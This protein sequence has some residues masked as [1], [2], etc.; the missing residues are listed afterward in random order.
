[1]KIV[2]LEF[3]GPF[4]WLPADDAEFI[5]DVE[6]S[7][8]P[9]IY[10]WTVGTQKGHLAWYVG[11]TQTS[12]HRRMKD[13]F[14]EQMSGSYEV[15]DPE[16]LA[17]GKRVKIWPGYYGRKENRRIPT[18]LDEAPSLCEAMVELARITR[19]FL[20]P[21]EGDKR[22]HLRVEGGIGRYLRDQPGVVGN[23]MDVAFNFHAP[24]YEG[25]EHLE[26]RITCPQEVR[27]LPER[28]VL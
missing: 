19:F 8:N 21:M 1:M 13:H 6:I 26:L 12:F 16:K 11:Q 25:E 15:Y 5:F 24:W 18:Y 14:K 28:L 4:A 27:G 3:H 17:E 10:L 22:L 7:K 23:F 2:E 9:G 20:A